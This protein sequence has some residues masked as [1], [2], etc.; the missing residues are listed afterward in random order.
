[1]AAGVSFRH[2]QLLPFVRLL[3]REVAEERVQ[4]RARLVE[5]AQLSVVCVRILVELGERI[6]QRYAPRTCT[7]ALYIHTRTHMHIHTLALY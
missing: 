6:R 5:V 1:M 7:L 4:P 2:L 3:R